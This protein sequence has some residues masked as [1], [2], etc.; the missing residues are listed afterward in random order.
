MLGETYSELNQENMDGAGELLNIVYASARA[1]INQAGY[2]FLP[3][4]PILVSGNNAP[5]VHGDAHAIARATCESEFGSLFLE[6]SLKKRV[7]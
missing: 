7:S 3:A 1:Q 4:L 5:Q 2:D 6:M